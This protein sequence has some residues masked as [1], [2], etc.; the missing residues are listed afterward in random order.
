MKANKKMLAFLAL[1]ALTAVSGEAAETKT[2]RLFKNITKNIQNNKPNNT[3]Y[4]LIERI[5]K[6][7][8]K[9]LNDLYLQNDY[10]VK[11]EYLEWQI[12]VS[13]VYS[14][15]DRGGKEEIVTN[16]LSPEAKSV[17]LGMYIPVTGMAK[18]PL[19]LNITPVDEPDVNV[20][21]LSVTTPQVTGREINFSGID[22][23]VSPNIVLIERFNSN[24]HYIYYHGQ[25]SLRENGEQPSE[26]TK[27]YEIQYLGATSK[28][29]E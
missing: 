11:P 15:K 2:D 5:L 23:P 18:S 19:S 7:K 1:N 27:E 8:N 13:G 3:N 10:I 14:N 28:M 12:F 22:I 9:E 26:S 21:V 6:E 29:T 17:N 4:K 16:K 20:K 24:D 25:K